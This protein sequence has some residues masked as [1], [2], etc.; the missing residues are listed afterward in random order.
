MAGNVENRVDYRFAN[1]VDKK[2][3]VIGLGALAVGLLLVPLAGIAI[4][5]AA[6]EGAEMVAAKSYKKRLREK[7]GIIFMRKPKSVI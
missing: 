4:N 1:A 3:A 2:S 5:V 7:G 6:I